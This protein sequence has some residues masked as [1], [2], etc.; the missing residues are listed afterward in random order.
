MRHARVISGPSD[1]DLPLEDDDWNARHVIDDY[2]DFP[3]VATPASPAANVLRVF[4]RNLGGRMLPAFVGPS[5]LD[6]SL[7]PFFGRNKVGLFVPA[8]NGGA[9]AQT[10]LA[11]STL[12]TATTEVVAT[13][14]LHNYMRRRSWRVTTASTTAV[15]TLRGSAAQFTIGG[16]SAG[17]GGFHLV[18]RWGPATGVANAAHRAFVGMRASTT[19]PTDVN[20][21]TAVNIVGMGYDSADT[22]VHIMHNDGTGSATKIPLGAGFPKPN[23]DMTSVYELALFTPPGTTQVVYYE[24]TNLVTGAV[25][26]GVLTTDLPTTTTLLALYSWMS[27][28]G[29]SGVIGLAT[30]GI[31]LETD[32]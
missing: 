4:G 27:V 28:G 30:T 26:T 8:G 15:V 31:Y 24:V 11:F 3:A 19:N 12:G 7:Q 21:S 18:W 20:P 25:A 22:Q 14:N 9:D 32:Y 13:T 10:G 23:V 29:V 17:L 5:G 2:L 16:P 6:S 1:P